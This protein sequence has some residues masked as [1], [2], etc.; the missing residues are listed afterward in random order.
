MRYE[1][2]IGIETPIK[3]KFQNKMIPELVEIIRDYLTLLNILRDNEN[4]TF[5][6]LMEDIS[7]TEGK[8]DEEEKSIDA[9]ASSKT[10]ISI[11]DIDI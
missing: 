1:D 7:F 6:K 9:P 4:A 8:G 10:K 3:Y 11:F 5:D 2:L